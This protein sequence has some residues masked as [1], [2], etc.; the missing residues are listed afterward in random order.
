[1]KLVGR[2][3]AKAQHQRRTAKVDVPCRIATA[4]AWPGRGQS[5]HQSHVRTGRWREWDCATR[6][7]LRSFSDDQQDARRQM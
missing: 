3:L 1:M 7:G 6:R 2:A 4:C 5:C